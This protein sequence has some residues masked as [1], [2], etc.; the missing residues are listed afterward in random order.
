MRNPG[1][2]AGGRGPGRRRNPS[3]RA[4]SPRAGAG[5]LASEPSLF[6]PG[7]SGGPGARRDAARREA[8]WT[9]RPWAGSG[10]YPI[11]GGA[12]GQGPIRGF[13]PA[14]GQP[15]PLYPPGPFSAWNRPGAPGDNGYADSGIPGL[16]SGSWP[17]LDH[18]VPGP[19]GPGQAGPGDADYSGAGYADASYPDLS[20]A[21]PGDA[22]HADPHYSALAVSDPA[23]DV[24]STQT[25]GVDD[26]TGWSDPGS[27]GPRGRHADSS[28]DRTPPAA[29]SGGLAGP[30][31]AA[32]AAAVPGLP[33]TGGL[34]A[35]AA[36][37]GL[38][39]PD[40]AAPGLGTPPGQTAPGEAAPGEAAPGEAAPGRDQDR[41]EDT[42]W[43][44]PARRPPAR[45]H[46]SRGR[47]RPRGRKRRGRVLLACALAAVVAVGG[48]A[49]LVLS[50]HH[51]P[52]APAA[53]AHR[54]APKPSPK[55][56]S[57]SPS[58]SLGPWGHIESRATDP[59]PLTLAELFPAQFADGGVNYL[60]TVQKARAHCA[61]AL[62]GGALTSAAGQAGCTQVMR[63]SYLS[64][65]KLMGTIG[66]LNLSTAAA[67][68]KAGKAAGPAEFIA[69]LPATTGPARRLTK[70]TGIEA[71][72]VK[73]HYL[74]L[75]WAEFTNL[76]A[77]RT[78]AQ[79]QQ[80]EAFISVLI[81]KTANVS[82]ASRMV[83]GLAA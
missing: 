67:A 80:L 20:Y 6:A 16:D 65:S 45:G 44:A 57:P 3:G 79:R 18:G 32:P 69:Q 13:P 23:A 72:E 35:Q 83:T 52:A 24:T 74:V 70:G 21:D 22:G 78:A 43:T 38:G 34:A 7:Y 61:G 75:V 33:G 31:A 68:A 76:R 12:A 62:I 55:D 25:W 29:G 59:A 5:Q 2:N 41:R 8:G 4:D 73:G 63:A 49:Y 50:G 15:P 9:D 58:P 10:P 39:A 14:P 1:E 40:Q 42:A 11:A 46:G 27:P 81:Q 64:S 71:A 37:P 19:A 77:P 60:R 36:A 82:L 54:T 66:V 47:A 30:D 26:A 51:Q 53:A 48:A 17:A 28:A 56:P